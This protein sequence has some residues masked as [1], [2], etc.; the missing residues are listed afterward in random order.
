MKN[1]Y[2]VYTS[3]YASENKLGVKENENKE[4]K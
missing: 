2:I 3:D 1:L 4:K